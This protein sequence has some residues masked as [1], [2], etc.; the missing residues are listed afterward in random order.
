MTI[1]TFYPDNVTVLKSDTLL[2]RGNEV[3]DLTGP[4]VTAY[5][6]NNITNL[7]AKNNKALRILSPTGNS[8]GFDVDQ[9]ADAVLVYN[10]ASRIVTGF[11]FGAVASLDVYNATVNNC[12]TGF[13]TASGGTFRNI[14]L[15]AV[16]GNSLYRV[17][18]GI[19]STAGTQLNVD[20]VVH[21]GLAIFASGLITE[22]DNI[23][24]E[25]ILYIDEAN[26]DLTPDYVSA[27]V[28]AGTDNPLLT[29]SSDIGGIESEVTT[30]ATAEVNY[31]YSLIDN[32][33]WNTADKFSVESSFI[34]AF[35]SRVLANTEVTVSKVQRDTHIKLAAS[36]TRFSEL[37][38]MHARYATQTRFKKRVMDMW[39][40]GQ[41]PATIQ[42]Y[43]NS[44]GGYNLFPSFFKRMEDYADGWIVG[45][46]FVAYDNWLNSMEDL[47]YGIGIDVLGTST[48]NQATSGE[49]YSNVMSTVADIAPVRW[50]LHDEVQPTGYLVFTD[51]WNGFENCTLTNMHYNDDFNL[52][53]TDVD[54]AARAVTPLIST[55]AILGSGVASGNVEISLLDRRFSE[56]VDRDFYFRQGTAADSMS[57]WE[58]LTVPIGSVLAVTDPYLQFRVDVDDA[59]SEIDYE[60][61]GVTLRTYTSARSWVR[62]QISTD[63]EY[64]E[65][66]PGASLP[67]N[68]SP[69]VY[70]SG[71]FSFP[72]DGAAH[73]AA[74]NIL[75]PTG[76]YA[77]IQTI[78][79]YFG[80][81][82]SAAARVRYQIIAA[83]SIAGLVAPVI[84]TLTVTTIAGS[85]VYMDI[86]L[87]GVF[88]ATTYAFNLMIERD[89]SVAGDVLAADLDYIMGRTL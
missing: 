78:R 39:Y 15:S 51:M 41:N 46:S 87:A 84:D 58:E 66:A 71:S 77:D 57:A 20:Y 61:M 22:G 17:A 28:N 62:P 8:T 14:A 88:T 40:A 50:F 33:F 42:A 43:Q 53:I 32:V 44:I 80:S 16:K 73:S 47:K 82:G 64:I 2:V 18:N 35:Q 56:D 79:M 24:E 11:D 23:T 45:V 60:F 37:Y 70:H 26:D 48:M 34:R 13:S 12:T 86:P 6:L 72:D 52:G 59:P 89:S 54:Q 7:R 3:S 9:V 38:P 21:S 30:E 29:A 76:M 27:L 81:S 1:P 74:W 67:D 68:G 25:L 85:L 4:T 49:C 19:V 69:P 63:F 65:F 10:T 55:L 75:L 36:M 83:D 31:W 5:K